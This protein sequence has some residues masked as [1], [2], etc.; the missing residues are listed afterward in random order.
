MMKNIKNLYILF[1]LICSSLALESCKDL[2]EINEN[3][4]GLTIDNAN[5]NLILPTVLTETAKLYNSL[6]YGRAAGIM[7]H[8]QKDAWA[9]SHNGIDWG[10]EDWGGYYN[11]LRN[12]QAIYNVAVENDLRF[13]QGVALVMKSFVFG[14][15][16]D[17]W[18]DAPYTN[19]LNGDLGGNENLLPVYDSQETIYNGI[20]AD[21][22]EA[23]Q[24]LSLPKG[25][26]KEILD[27]A[28]IFY[29][30]DPVKWQK[31]AN[32]LLLRYLMRV[33]L[34]KDVQSDFASVAQSGNL[35]LD[36]SDNV[37]MSFLGNTSG[38]AW[39]DNADPAFDGTNGSNYRRIKACETLVEALR[40]KNDPRIAVWF[41][42]VEIPSKFLTEE[43]K[44]TINH[45]DIIDGV[46]YLDEEFLISE[47]T[48]FNVSVNPDYV[49]APPQLE[50]TH[51]FNLNTEPAQSS[52]NSFVS[53][54]NERYRE[55]SGPLLRARLMTAAEVNFLLAEAAQKGWI[56]GAENY[57]NQGIT[58]SMQEWGVADNVADYLAQPN[59][60]YDGS[61]EQI[62]EQKW[63]ASW[64][65]AQEAWY[66]YRRTG[67]P[68][69]QM[70]PF[71]PRPVFPLRFIYGNNELNFNQANASAAIDR[72]E[73]TNFSQNDKNSPWSKP[74]LIAGTGK[75]Y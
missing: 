17:I 34:K 46:R 33:S 21:L 70:G 52:F 61:L 18:G 22:K 47:G 6:G 59:V 44:A 13:H 71:S 1:I 63:M 75:P 30:G 38:D 8:T 26:Y 57:Y 40:E 60:A 2:S 10:P 74:W 65:A 14:Q 66:D 16:A 35:I 50:S 49:G 7:Q 53:F 23:S 68:A 67:L 64:T 29:N 54:L 28:D 37:Y 3:P 19:A 41:E 4:N 32:S 15:I 9:G 31:F 62:I 55:S 58:A 43:E 56:S 45:L 5:V 25:E 69:L 73:L 24:L 39:P 27:Q 36:N 11:I 20:I 72:L 12:N 42:P 48:R 51:G